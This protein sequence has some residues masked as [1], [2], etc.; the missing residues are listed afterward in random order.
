MTNRIGTYGASQQYLFNM[1]SLQQRTNKEELQI[2]SGKISQTYSGIA[3]AANSVLNYQVL[4]TETQ[5]Y[6]TDN[7][8]TTTKLQAASSAV[9]GVQTSITTFLNQL[10]NFQ[11]NGAYDQGSIN[12]LQTFAFQGLQNIQAYLNSNINGEYLFSG[13]KTSTAPMQMQSASLSQFQSQ[14]NGYTITYPTTTGGDL[15]TAD[16]T[17]KQSTS[18]SFQPSSGTIVA[19][20][21]DAL[22]S[23]ATGS[24]ITVANSTSNN[25]TYTVRSQASTNILGA[26]LGETTTAAGAGASALVTYGSSAT[27]VTNATT[28]NL[29]FAFAANGQ[30]TITPTNANTLSALTTGT[31]F[32]ISGSTGNAWDGSYQV[33]SNLN[34]VV[35]IANDETPVQ[36]EQV[37]STALSLTDNT[38]A[39]TPALTSGKLT[40]S[41]SA[42]SATGLTTVT[43]TAAGATDFSGISAGD[44]V[45]LSGTADHNGTYKVA[46]ATGNAI[47]FTANPTAIRVSQFLPQS[48]R[49]DVTLSGTDPSGNQSTFTKQEYTSLSFS[50]TGVGGETITAATAN[51]FKDAHGAV[52][53]PPGSLLNLASTSGVNDGNYVVVSNDGTNIVVKSNTLTTETNSTTATIS[54]TSYYKG[55][56]LQQ[57]QLIDK[58]RSVSIG[59]SAADPAFEKAIRAMGIIAQ[60]VYGT[61][62]GLDQNKNRISNAIWLLNDSLQ[63]PAAGTPPYGQESSSD[64]NSVT[65]GL[66]YTQNIISQKNTTDTQLTGYL[67]TQ[68]SAQENIDPTTAVTTLLNDSNALQAAYQAVAQIRNLSL[69]TYLK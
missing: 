68:I 57:S 44:Y 20:Q 15:L 59:T 40:F 37:Q 58:G 51:A 4:N 53:P 63:S 69:M 46:S 32:T 10:K 35:T 47:T 36:S 16:I 49:T 56:S 38:T 2:S 34:G 30:M 11:Q 9:G 65:Q 17:P 25:N 66:G 54:A 7:S 13:G 5:Q 60:G 6:Q 42:S 27:K 23:V 3:A 45:T 43:L 21:A 1:L 24:T 33:V 14:Y 12:Q 19:A 39:A 67:Q 64:I 18:L 8:I 22:D 50:P 26:A 31:K 61:A 29:N 52:A 48:G 28:G 41:S 55:D 62:G